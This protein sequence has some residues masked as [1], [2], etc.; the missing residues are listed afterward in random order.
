MKD[1]DRRKHKTIDDGEIMDG[2]MGGWMDDYDGRL[3]GE[4]WMLD[5]TQKE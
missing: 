4:C 2:R 5:D 3:I 1:G